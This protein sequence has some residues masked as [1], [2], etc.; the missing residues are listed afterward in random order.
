MATTGGQLGAVEAMTQDW[1]VL[2]E[3]VAS[4]GMA[5]PVVFQE[6]AVIRERV[7]HP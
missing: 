7:V 5:D 3:W 4:A 1:V 6:T 2:L